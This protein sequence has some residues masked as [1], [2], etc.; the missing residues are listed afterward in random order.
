MQDT[1]IKSIYKKYIK[2]K[3][4]RWM[5]DAQVGLRVM[6]PFADRQ[7]CRQQGTGRFWGSE[8]LTSVHRYYN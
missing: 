4:H 2:I 3:L 1:E 5:N 7:A 6:R 8:T